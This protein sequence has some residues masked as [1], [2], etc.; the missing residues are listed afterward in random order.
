MSMRFKHP[1]NGYVEEVSLAPLWCLLFG[2][3]YFAVKGVWTHAVA[4]LALS[5]FTFGIS[6]LIYPFFANQIMRA[7]YLRR[8]WLPDDN[9]PFRFS[10]DP[11]KEP[12]EGWAR[13]VDQKIAR[14]VQ[15]TEQR[16]PQPPPPPT[17]GFGKRQVR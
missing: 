16:Q 3:I 1:A 5:I 4:G 11:G 8:G 13:N 17:A 15:E 2:F 6:W 9:E 7:H 14:Y 10:P 12:D